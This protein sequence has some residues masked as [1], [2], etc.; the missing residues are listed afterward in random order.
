[1]FWTTA[2]IGG[3]LLAAPGYGAPK[4]GQPAPEFT[5]PGHDGK[6]YDL[7][8]LRGK[9]VVLEWFNNDCPYV[10]KH[11]DGKVRNMQTLQRRWIDEAKKSKKELVWFAIAS[12]APEKQGHLTAKEAKKIRDEERNAHM[13][14]ILLDP[15][16]AVGKL[17]DAKTTPHMFVIDPKGVLRYD[18]AIDDKPSTQ[19]ST[20][21]GAKN[22]VTESLSSLFEGKAIAKEQSTP[23]GCSVKYE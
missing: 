2:L 7:K 21:K 6:T 4:I 19:L 23:Y 9:Y 18:G 20:L 12:S 16:G 11:Y 5:L 3:L 17:Y 15:K 1:M 14:S 8:A 13:T 10:D 22:Y